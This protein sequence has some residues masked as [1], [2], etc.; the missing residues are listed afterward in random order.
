MPVSPTASATDAM[1]TGSERSRRVATSG[2]SRCSRTSVPISVDV[3]GWQPD[4]GRHRLGQRHADGAVVTG[5]PLADVVQ[6]GAEQQQ[7]GAV[8]LAGV[9][10]GLVGG[11]HEV[12]V[13]GVAVHRVVLGQAAQ[14]G[15]LGQPAVDQPVPVAGLPG[16]H[17]AGTGAEQGGQRGPGARPARARAAAGSTPPATPGG[18]GDR[19]PG[20]GRRGGHPQGQ[21]RV[22]AGADG[23]PGQHQ[24]AVVLDHVP[25]DRATRGSPVPAP[26]AAGAQPVGGPEGVVEGVAD[27]AGVPG[28]PAQQGVRAVVAGPSSAATPSR[29]WA[30]SRS[31]RRPTCWCRASRVSSRRR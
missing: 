11:L 10:A 28:D 21:A 1:V 3:R 4:P 25:G 14:P 31:T 26:G 24:L 13:E 16:R 2:S 5:K 18:S 30:T 8:H 20:R 15:P 29:S 17:Q 23:R 6:Q 12:P 22:G 27:R 19:Q 7:V 9:P